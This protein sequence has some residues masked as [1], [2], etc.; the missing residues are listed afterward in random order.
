MI[1]IS[2]GSQILSVS[3]AGFEQFYKNAGWVQIVKKSDVSPYE[4][5]IRSAS[6]NELKK[7]A[8]EKGI[9][10]TGASKRT[11]IDALLNK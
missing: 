11:L 4:S 8:Q 5:K 10:T 1:K 7:M 2:N 6:I 3:K 9:D